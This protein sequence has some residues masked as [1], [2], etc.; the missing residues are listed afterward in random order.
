MKKFFM[1]A[2]SIVSI[3]SIVVLSKQLEKSL[4]VAN[5]AHESSYTNYSYDAVYS[6][7][8]YDAYY[9][10]Y[11]AD[12]SYDT[13]NTYYDAGSPKDKTAP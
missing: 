7:V 12:Y 9:D 11:D 1:F 8:S 13:Y 5:A 3:A 4:V 10:S 2:L 6:N